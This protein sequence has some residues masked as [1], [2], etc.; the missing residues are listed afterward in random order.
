MMVT[1]IMIGILEL[2]GCSP[3]MMIGGYQPVDMSLSH[4]REQIR[5]KADEL[6]ASQKT[7]DKRIA[8]ELYG[9]IMELEL[10]DK[11]IAEYFDM[12]PE[13]G[14]YLLRKGEKIH[15]FYELPH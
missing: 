12:E 13:M 1:S 6:A 10:M 9:S 14:M 7:M 4:Y 5:S 11:S 8:A 3:E 2:T 15:K